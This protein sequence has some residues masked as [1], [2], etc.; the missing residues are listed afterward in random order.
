MTEN[1]ALEQAINRHFEGDLDAAA[2]VY[3]SVLEDDP[4]NA[5]A[6]HYYGIYLHQI[7]KHNE[8]IDKLQLSCALAP[9]NASWHNDLGN[10]L[11]NLSQYEMAVSAY[12]DAL[13]ANAADHMVWNNMGAALLRLGKSEEAAEAFSRAVDISP[14]FVSALQ[15]LGV[16]Y[17]QAG[18][19]MK[20]SHYQCRAYVVPPMEGKS[21]DLVGISFYFLGRLDEAAQL[22]REWLQDEPENAVAEHMLAACSQKE[23]PARASDRYIEQHFDK[24]AETFEA[25]LLE[26]LAYKGAAMIS[27]GLSAISAPSNQFS[28]VDIGCGTGIC[29]PVLEPYSS[30]LVGVDLSGKMLEKAALRGCYDLLVRGEV[31]GYLMANPQAY[32][33]V[34]AADTL[35]Y[36][37]DLAPLFEKVSAALRSGGYFIFTVESLEAAQVRE[38]GYLLHAS[39]RYKHGCNYVIRRLAPASL[40][41][42]HH[43]FHTI[44]TEVGVDVPGIVFVARKITDHSERK[45]PKTTQEA[46]DGY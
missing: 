32:D 45:F 9:E 13:E 38:K 20:A 40:E 30:S 33:L 36:F 14:E 15:N 29:G 16:I 3:L 43:S 21:R 6:L 4:I 28:V 46:G 24:Y 41:L 22:Y 31:G 35:I 25:N 44:R 17:E 39:G 2:Q 27:T 37:G 12:S 10:V 18:D 8:A 23:V 1:N 26:S 34:A 7:G 42:V 11:F 5:V 19:K